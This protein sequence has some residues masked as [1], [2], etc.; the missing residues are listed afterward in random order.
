MRS[1]SLQAGAKLDAA[2]GFAAGPLFNGIEA[3]FSE[4]SVTDPSGYWF[5]HEEHILASSCD[6]TLKTAINGFAR[7]SSSRGYL[8]RL[9]QRLGRE[10]LGEIGE[11]PR[12]KRSRTNGSAVV[13]SHVDDRH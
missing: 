12:L 2:D 1:A 10:W 11:A 6:G 9:P 13:P 3:F 5:R 8:E 4:S 7:R